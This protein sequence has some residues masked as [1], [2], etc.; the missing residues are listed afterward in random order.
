MLQVQWMELGPVMMTTMVL[1]AA[2]AT[3]QQV[4]IRG[5]EA[6]TAAAPRLKVPMPT[7]LTLLL[8]LQNRAVVSKVGGTITEKKDGVL[9]HMPTR[10]RQMQRTVLLQVHMPQRQRMPGTRLACACYCY[11]CYGPS[12]RHRWTVKG[13]RGLVEPPA[14]RS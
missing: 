8:V 1:V 6:G 3:R 7:L 13:N 2:A 5:S 9:H 14:K 10:P 4:A 11:R 12:Q